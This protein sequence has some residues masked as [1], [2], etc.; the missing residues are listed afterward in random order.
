MACV[1]NCGQRKT[2]GFSFRFAALTSLLAER[3]PRSPADET[4]GE[5]A[6]LEIAAEL[7]RDRSRGRFPGRRVSVIQQKLQDDAGGNRNQN[8]VAA[9]LN[10]MVTTGRGTQIV[11]APVIDHIIPVAVFDRKAIAPVELMVWACAAFVPSLVRATPVFTAIRLACFVVATILLAAALCLFI[12]TAIVAIPITL[13][14]GK[15]S[16]GQRHCHDG[17]NN[18]FTVHAG[19]HL[20]GKCHIRLAHFV[21]RPVP[22]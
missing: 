4:V 11:A 16:R 10:P 19:L 12:A 9:C 13:G 17:G 8:I 18:C 22:T 5:N 2:V 6:A 7:P 3:H 21:V 14:E 20:V 1:S 15:S